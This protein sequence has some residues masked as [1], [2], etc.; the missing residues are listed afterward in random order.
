MQSDGTAAVLGGPHVF[1]SGYSLQKQVGPAGIITGFMAQVMT[2][3]DTTLPNRGHTVTSAA[4]PVVGM[5][6][7]ILAAAVVVVQ[8]DVSKVLAIAQAAAQ[9]ARSVS[10]GVTGFSTTG[11]GNGD[12]EAAIVAAIL[13][14]FDKKIGGVPF[15]ITNAAHPNFVGNATLPNGKPNPFYQLDSK[16]TNA[17]HFG[18]LAAEN[19]VPGAGAAGVINYTHASLS[20]MPVTDIFGL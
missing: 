4:G 3:G 18:R 19:G 6:G 7:Q 15:A 13:F 5:V 2:A 9:A 16:V 14:A 10:P 11:S 20:G 1:S 8:A 12:G 17:V